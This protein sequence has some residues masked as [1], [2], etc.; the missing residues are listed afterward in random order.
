V[1]RASDDKDANAKAAK[2]SEVNTS[3]LRS[4]V[5]KFNTKVT[6]YLSKFT[7]LKLKCEIL[8]ELQTH[9]LN[10]ALAKH[11]GYK[12][13]ITNFLTILFFGAIPNIINL[14]ATNGRNFLFFKQTTSESRV[15][16]ITDAV[17]VKDRLLPDS[18]RS[19]S[20]KS[21]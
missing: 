16:D 1:E 21:L 4:C 15:T 13:L 5:E 19:L 9:N 2:L 3:L 14:I 12:R 20:F 6:D 11:R 17:G 7:N 10:A 18:L 8:Q